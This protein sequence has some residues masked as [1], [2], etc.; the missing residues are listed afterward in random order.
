MLAVDHPVAQVSVQI[1]DDK[2]VVVDVE[3]VSIGDFGTEVE[4][5]D[6]SPKGRGISARI[7]QPIKEDTRE[8]VCVS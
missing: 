1:L 3:F 4:A 7:V 6:R 5:A 2:I 8:L